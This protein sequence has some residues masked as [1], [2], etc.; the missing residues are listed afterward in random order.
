M[1]FWAKTPH[2]RKMSH[3]VLMDIFSQNF[4]SFYSDIQFTLMLS[5]LSKGQHL[6]L[7]SFEG[8]LQLQSF[9]WSLFLSGVTDYG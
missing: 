2:L 4:S 6:V 9:P 5:F 7:S 8:V 1:T 3:F